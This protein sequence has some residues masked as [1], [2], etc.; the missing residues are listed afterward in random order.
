VQSDL[1]HYGSEGRKLRAIGEKLIAEG[2]E[3]TLENVKPLADELGIPHKTLKGIFPEIDEKELKQHR[4]NVGDARAFMAMTFPPR[5]NILSPWIPRQGLAM[6]YA[7]RGIGKTHLSLEIAYVVA[8]GG[9]LF[10]WDA[11][12]PQGVL[13]IDGEM[14]GA[15]LQERLARIATSGEKE[16]QAPLR[17]ITPDLQP[18]G[19]IDL[20]RCDD[21]EELKQNLG[22]ISLI[23]LDNIS[24]L[25]RSGRENESESWLPVQEWALLQR[26]AGRSVLFIHHSGKGGQQRGTSRREDVLDTVI[27]LR[28]PGDYSPDQGA[29][30]EVH[31]EK[32][33]GIYGDDTKP[34]E[35]RLTTSEDGTQKW[36]T[37]ALEESTAEKVAHLLSEDI[38]QKEIA[39]ML[40]ITPGA[41]SKAKKRATAMGLI[42]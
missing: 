38:P 17:I 33:R 40:N 30:F 16:P 2:K 19:I 39:A 4:I 31:F 14:P 8:S 34:F 9:S 6:I 41:V 22:G 23:I 20:S 10:S 5:E 11:P 29:T 42:T 35:A 3:P 12:K 27:A 18:K 26:A 1:I 7:L 13:F 36:L 37:K 32:A 15:V 25:C 24:T 21:Q 28:H